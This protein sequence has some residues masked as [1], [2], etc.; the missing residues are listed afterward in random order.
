MDLKE[1]VIL[2]MDNSKIDANGKVSGI[3]ERLHTY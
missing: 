1:K 3:G 2:E